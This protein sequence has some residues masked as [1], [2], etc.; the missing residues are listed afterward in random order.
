MPPKIPP[1]HFNEAEGHF[2]RWYRVHKNLVNIAV[3][4]SILLYG[5][6]APGVVLLL[7]SLRISGYAGIQEYVVY[8]S[9]TLNRT[10]MGTTHDFP[11]QSSFSFLAS[12]KGRTARDSIPS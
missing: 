1:S 8:L 5:H 9:Q 4:A 12:H 3:G 10:V 2:L 7:S 6:K 11:L